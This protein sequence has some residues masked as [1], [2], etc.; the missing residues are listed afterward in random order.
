MRPKASTT[1][2]YDC[3]Y[4]TL[5][6]THFEIDMIFTYLLRL[7]DSLQ[8]IQNISIDTKLNDCPVN[9]PD[10]FNDVHFTLAPK[11]GT[12]SRAQSYEAYNYTPTRCYSILY[13]NGGQ[14]QKF[15]AVGAESR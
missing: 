10:Q 14:G 1:K 15:V 2:I 5:R 13:Y 11:Q 7:T 4:Q 12:L 8:K 6:D 9:F 3:S